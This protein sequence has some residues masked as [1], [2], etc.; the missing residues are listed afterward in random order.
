M[1]LLPLL[2]SKSWGESC[3]LLNNRSLCICCFIHQKITPHKGQILSSLFLTDMP[4]TL[5][6][7]LI[8]THLCISFIFVRVLVRGTKIEKTAACM[9]CLQAYVRKFNNPNPLLLPSDIL[10][11][12]LLKDYGIP[13]YSDT[14]FH[15]R[16]RSAQV[17]RL[18]LE[19]RQRVFQFS[20]EIKTAEYH[21]I[22]SKNNKPIMYYEL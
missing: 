4:Y 19:K 8:N 15:F 7:Y 10:T 22:Q 5:L 16:K 1:N 11:E 13:S 3:L 9:P 17:I 6:K 14:L 18:S 20:I 2:S 12:Q 21:P